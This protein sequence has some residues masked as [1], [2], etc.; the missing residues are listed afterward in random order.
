MKN[1]ILTIFAVVFL[2]SYGFG[3]TFAVNNFGDTN[4][5][6]T[7][8]DLCAD[9]SGNCTLRAAVQQ[10]NASTSDDIITFAAGLQTITLNI[11]TEIAISGNA[12]TLQINGPGANVLTVA[13]KPGG[14]N[15]LFNLNKAVVT[16]ADLTLTGGFPSTFIPTAIPD[17]DGG[18]ILATGGSLTIQRLNITGNTAGI[19]G[20]NQIPRGYGGGIALN[21][22]THLFQNST[23]SNNL[24]S[25]YGGGI[26]NRSGNLTVVNCTISSNSSVGYGGGIYNTGNLI[27]RNATIANNYVYK[28]NGSSNLGFGGGIANLE[29]GTVIFNNTIIAGNAVQNT[30]GNPSANELFRY[31]MSSYTSTGNNFI[32][33]SEGD[34]TNTYNLINYQPTDIRDIP[35]QLAALA[36]SG[37]TTPT[38]ALLPSSPAI[39]AGNNDN[40]P[41]TDQRGAPRV[42]AVDIGAYEFGALTFT[43]SGRVTTDGASGFGGVTVTLS[44]TSSTTV[45]TNSNGE[46]S[47]SGLVESGN[48]TVTPSF[49]NTVFSPASAT[50]NGL[51]GNQTVNFRPQC[52]YSISPTS[53]SISAA[54]G[55]I[56]VSVTASAGCSWTATSNDL[57]IVVMNGS[58]SGTG[59]G[60][61]IL[62][63]QE[64]PGATPRTG[65]VTIAGRTFTVT[66]TA[67][68]TLSINNV[69]QFEGNAGTTPFVFTVTLS[70]ASSQTV[71]VNYATVNGTAVPPTDYQATA[72]SL[73]FAPGETSKTITI[74]VNGDTT[75]EGDETFFV[76][77]S[78]A[79]NALIATSNGTGTIRNDDGIGAKPRYDFDGDGRADV[80]VFRPSN[81]TW[82]LAQSTNGFAGIAFGAGDDV[83]V[84]ADYD[85]DGKTDIAVF[86]P[87]NGTWYLNRSALGFTA[88]A[89]GVSSDIP[90]PA[91]YD[92]DGKADVAVFR[93][94]T[95]YWY[96]STNPAIN[97][98]AV[99]FGQTGDKPV[100]A[101]Y[102]GDGKADVAVFRPSN[103]TWYLQRSSLGFTGIAFGASSDLP[104]PAD[105][106][107][108]GKAD[109]AVFRPS[110]G[111]WYTSTNPASNYGAVPFGMNGDLPVPADYDGDGKADVAVFRPSN[112][113]WY[114]NRSAQGFTGVAFGA[115]ED[116]PIPNAFIR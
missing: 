19:F 8:D 97:Y 53:A 107:G 50:F 82:Y 104:V 106:D 115:S 1:F 13:G 68:P 79:T 114:L 33:D 78:N 92:G 98:G 85:G 12:G 62:N 94:S 21:G 30:T 42:G 7:A 35:P 67:L 46:Y 66:Q 6:N 116:K 109:V 57:F 88:V 103:G 11:G 65:T 96:T 108:D 63:V 56:S 16:I 86:R 55:S 28:P 10:A 100:P 47:F 43:I 54:G 22:G 73:S 61:V 2:A 37:G 110:T 5:A 99:L 101:D 58:N 39:N 83:I 40:A 18:A 3:A 4:D 38:R 32:G 60:T 64:N 17:A 14:N 113:A 41:A 52:E 89:F 51:S 26:S 72:S 102:D 20:L 71:T 69:S 111:Y 27:V 87:S 74:L 29:T 80:T 59:N 9:S 31:Y 95:G 77:L 36:N 76:N 75:N 70:T 24:A 90:V 49:P 44:G 45:V 23:F 91:D 105:Y 25:I 93:P 34:S 112:G 48:Y 15:R 81:G 84:P